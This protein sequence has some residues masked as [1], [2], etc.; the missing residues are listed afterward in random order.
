VSYL[1]K[2]NLI[3]DAFNTDRL[4]MNRMGVVHVLT[5]FHSDHR[6]GLSKGFRGRLLCSQITAELVT[7]LLNVSNLFIEE[8]SLGEEIVIEPPSEQHLQPYSI[9]FIDANHCPGSVSLIVK[10][11]GFAFL[12]M[13]DARVT[14]DLIANIRILHPDPFDL[15][16]IDSTFYDERGLW[17]SMP[18]KEESVNALVEFIKQNRYPIG[19]EFELLGTE[20]LIDAILAAFPGERIIVTNEQR[21]AE[22]EIIYSTDISTL[23]RLIPYT[24]GSIPFER[25]RF[26]IVSRHTE[27]P[28]Q[29]VRLRA[30]T[31]RWVQRIR[32]LSSEEK[33]P[34]VE[35]DE[36][37]HEC[38]VFF[39]MHS[40]KK[41]IDALLS[42]IRAK[43][44]EKLVKPI[45]II[46]PDEASIETISVARG[47][48]R[49]DRCKRRPFEFSMDKMWLDELCDSQDTVPP[50]QEIDDILLPTWKDNS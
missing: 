3:V 44:V 16:W 1:C 34:I 2:T 50:F 40:C 28:K 9:T 13:G 33:C 47:Q 20:I 4:I 42:G 39:S 35:Y 24:Q 27:L 41:E 37:A 11:L 26:F 21:M 17:D 48:A 8:I 5:H 38:F 18:S 6:S 14:S 43:S 30:T 46:Q 49:R 12:H 36:L 23:S 10:G 15:V 32:S 19:L 22:L 7:G 31:Q 45:Q 29:V 25:Y